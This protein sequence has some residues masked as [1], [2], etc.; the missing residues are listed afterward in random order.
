MNAKDDLVCIAKYI[1]FKLSSPS[2]A[3]KQIK[4]I[5]TA[6]KNLDEFPNMYPLCDNN[7]WKTRGLR[8]MPLDNYLVFYLPDEDHKIAKIYRVF[9]AKRDI[10]KKLNKNITFE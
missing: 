1:T 6:I 10:D 4:R 8:A 5:I 7:F 2:I 3:Q 9:Y